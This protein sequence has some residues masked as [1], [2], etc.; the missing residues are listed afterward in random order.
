M[1]QSSAT[2]KI[3]I[4]CCFCDPIFGHFRTTHT[5]IRQTDRCM[6]VVLAQHHMV[7]T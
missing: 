5:C 7:K 3:K 1:S 4:C 6:A 2:A